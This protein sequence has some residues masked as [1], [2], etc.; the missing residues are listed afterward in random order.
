MTMSNSLTVGERI[1]IYLGRY[2]RLKDSFDVPFDVSQDGIA[3]SLG[4]SRAHAAIELK[5]LKETGEVEERLAHIKRGRNKRKV[6]FL[7]E[8]GERRATDVAEYAQ[9]EGI[10][11]APLLDIRRSKGTD[12]YCSLAPE[13]KPLVA[14]ACVFRRP[15]RREA[16]PESS[17]MV[18]PVDRRGMVDLPQ[19]LA[20]EIETLL[21]REE[22]K[23][24]HSRA[25][26]YWLSEGDPRERLYHLIKAGR[27]KEAE[28]LVAMRP[29]AFIDKGDEPLL[30][31]I[32]GIESPSER[33]A[34]RVRTVQG[35]LARSLKDYNYC[36]EVCGEMQ[37]SS[38]PEEIAM[39]L[40]IEGK[41][42]RDTG[43]AEDGLAKLRDAQRVFDVGPQLNLEIAETLIQIGKSKDALS[44]LDWSLQQQ[45]DPEI[46]ERGQLLAGIAHL[47]AHNP[48]EALRYLSKSIAM[49][50]KKDKKEWY[51]ALAEAYQMA[52][53]PE[54]AR[55]FEA[56]ANPPK[57]WGE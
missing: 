18:L 44:V 40:L 15:F 17:A 22:S 55:E 24:H 31:I 53:M 11:L 35:E 48:N 39:G 47:R 38:N 21:T 33:Y 41:M 57:K 51:S 3:G 16:L 42:M 50:K 13:L 45:P 8:S 25:A 54:R 26:D 27:K 7:T 56:K 10:E 2:Q 9:R 36:A 12:F 32:A 5:K 43:K 52:Q 1:I 37:A 6:Y 34:S 46:I 23:A 29:S 19:D 14:G 49:T 20:R 30:E 4:I 28:M